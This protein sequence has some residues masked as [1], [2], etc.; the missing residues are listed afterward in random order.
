LVW[1]LDC[2]EVVIGH[3]MV[4]VALISWN[5]V[6]WSVSLFDRGVSPSRPLWHGRAARSR[7]QGWPQATAAGGA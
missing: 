7:G 6:A 2:Q 4:V 1:V 3:C 5:E